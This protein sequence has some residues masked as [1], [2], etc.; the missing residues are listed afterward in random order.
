MAIIFQNGY[1]VTPNTQFSDWE[2][3]MHYEGK[4]VLANQWTSVESASLRTSMG[5]PGTSAFMTMTENSTGADTK[6]DFGDGVGLYSAFF[7]KTDITKVAFVDGSS[8]SLDPTQHTNY[9]IYELVETTASESFDDILKRL[10]IYQ[11]D[12]AGF[13]TNDIVWPDPSVLNHTAGTNGYSGLLIASGGG[14]FLTTNFGM[15]SGIPQIPDKFVVMGINRDADNDVQAL[16][17]FW[18]NLQTGKAD[19][20]RNQNPSQTFWSYWGQDFHTN[21]KTQRIG[22]TL[23]TAPGVATGAAW[24]GS[25]YMLAF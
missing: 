13:Q 21:S 12:A 19:S 4:K 17:A 23:Q 8:T 20:W 18:G 3:V 22:S 7:N 10:D 9:L 1:S 24:N 6:T 5:S 2:I 16:C 15:T 11:R 25:V 14:D